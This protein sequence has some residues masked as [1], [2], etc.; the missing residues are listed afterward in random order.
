MSTAR[1]VL[2]RFGE[3]YVFEGDDSLIKL[4]ERNCT[5]NIVGTN[6]EYVFNDGSKVIV[7]IE[8]ALIEGK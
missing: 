6:K 4:L 1:S 3:A 8:H 5:L 2:K 7:T